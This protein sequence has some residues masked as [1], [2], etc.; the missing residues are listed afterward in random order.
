M[1]QEET[2]P[3]ILWDEVSSFERY[4]KL[5]LK[6]G[7]KV[8]VTFM[9]DGNFVPEK[10]LKQSGAKYARDSHVFVVESAGEKK[11]F[12]ASTTAHSTMRQ[13]KDI[14]N[15]N[16]NTLKGAKATMARVSEEADE[17]NY[18]IKSA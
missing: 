14:R 17:T 12:W 16:G 8:T 6:K 4:P 9:D 13:L 7:D 15:S 10:A 3:T 18:E 5:S 1:Q 2:M 11:E